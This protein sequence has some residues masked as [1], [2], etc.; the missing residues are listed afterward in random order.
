M[1]A[2]LQTPRRPL[3]WHPFV[4]ALREA[5]PARFNAYLVGG[6]VRDAYLGRPI[7]DVDLATPG[8]GRPLARAIADAFAGDYYPLDA[9][10][11]IG[12]AIVRW[13]S[14]RLIVDVAQFRGE[15]LLADLRGRDFTVNAM[16]VPLHGDL[17]HVIDP[18]GG[19]ADLDLKRLRRK[20]ARNQG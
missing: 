11:G 13:D 6:T 14:E 5:V 17:G 1:P 16:A 19:L 8:D 10:R 12:R 2:E 18:L 20:R 7:H 4:E 9:E 15:D 3:I